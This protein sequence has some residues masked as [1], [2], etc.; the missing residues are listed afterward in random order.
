[1]L[2]FLAGQSSNSLCVLCNLIS[3]P[4]FSCTHHNRY[5]F[6]WYDVKQAA[7]CVLLQRYFLAHDLELHGSSHVSQGT[8][9]A[10]TDHDHNDE[11]DPEGSDEDDSDDD[12][13]EGMQFII[14][15]YHQSQS[16]T[17]KHN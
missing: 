15:I 7:P 3:T 1:M 9:E 6:S 12:S 11:D 17:S 16:K 5:L 4:K 13:D 10:H 14:L 2:Q 8:D